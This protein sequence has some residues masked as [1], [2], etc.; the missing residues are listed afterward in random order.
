MT[1]VTSET[2]YFLGD[3]AG[4]HAYMHITTIRKSSTSKSL[5]TTHP[6]VLVNTTTFRLIDGWQMT[7][8]EETEMETCA[9]QLAETTH[10]LLD[11]GRR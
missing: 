1:R 7:T 9:P 4:P 6:L 8:R 11:R 5:P 3:R 10:A 2:G